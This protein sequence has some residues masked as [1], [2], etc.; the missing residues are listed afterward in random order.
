MTQLK[1]N[2]DGVN[3]LTDAMKKLVKKTTEAWKNAEKQQNL[4]QLKQN[5]HKII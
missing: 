2:M 1:Q 4:K 3:D 5:T